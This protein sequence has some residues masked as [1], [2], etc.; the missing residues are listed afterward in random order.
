M[1]IKDRVSEIRKHT[2]ISFHHVD[3][4]DNQ[5]DISSQ[6]CTTEVL[7]SSKQWWHGQKRLL[8]NEGKWLI[9]DPKSFADNKKKRHQS[10]NK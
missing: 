6:A 3:S 2:D 7:I 5:A 4:K 10:T 9:D 1:F 8:E